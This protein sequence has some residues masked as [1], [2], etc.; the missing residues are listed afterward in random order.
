VLSGRN[1]VDFQEAKEE[2]LDGE[3]SS[4]LYLPRLIENEYKEKRKLV[5]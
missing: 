2:I 3:N 1:Q 5:S 4:T